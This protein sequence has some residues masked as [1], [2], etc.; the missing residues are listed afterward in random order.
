MFNLLDS[1]RLG[2]QVPETDT[3]TILVCMKGLNVT[4]FLSMADITQV[5]YT[6]V[7]MDPNRSGRTFAT[8]IWPN[9]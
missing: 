7:E 2:Y 5:L 4:A 3:L 8:M 9:L 6:R 1:H